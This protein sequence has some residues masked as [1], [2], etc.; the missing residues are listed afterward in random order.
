MSDGHSTSGQRAEYLGIKGEEVAGTGET[1]ST[2][3]CLSL[4]V[5]K[6]MG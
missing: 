6:R 3:P 5:P 2:A 4:E 1:P